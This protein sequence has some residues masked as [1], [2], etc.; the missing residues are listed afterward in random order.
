ML[1]IVATNVGGNSLVVKD[2]FN[3]F[4]VRPRD[5]VSLYDKIRQLLMDERLRKK[6]GRNSRAL[7]ED[8]FDVE[9]MIRR[10]EAIYEKWLEFHGLY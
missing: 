10:Y 2:G 4:T 9:R 3:G 7:F 5:V 6:Y 1:P 8:D